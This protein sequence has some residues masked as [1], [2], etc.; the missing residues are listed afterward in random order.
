MYT[1]QSWEVFGSNQSS[2]V[3]SFSLIHN[4]Q[5]QPATRKARN[6]PLKEARNLNHN[7]KSSRNIDKVQSLS[8][9]T[10]L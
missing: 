9:I 1:K 3:L 8:R 2:K 5:T 10:P 4:N 6:R 7:I